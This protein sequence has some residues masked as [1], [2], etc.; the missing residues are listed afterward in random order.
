MVILPKY[1][2][3]GSLLVFWEFISLFV[4]VMWL[5]KSGC[6]QQSLFC[7]ST[8]KLNTDSY[9]YIS[10]EQIGNKVFLCVCAFFFLH[11]KNS[12]LGLE[13]FGLSSGFLKRTSNLDF[14][15]F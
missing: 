7:K 14:F 11:K 10:L 13:S 15:F 2:Q 5:F 8:K 12:L 4:F 6:V 3:A 1:S 9:D